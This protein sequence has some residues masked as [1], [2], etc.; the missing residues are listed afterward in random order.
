VRYDTS[1]LAAPAGP[2][3]MRVALATF[4]ANRRMSA[5]P[6]CLLRVDP[7]GIERTETLARV[8]TVKQGWVNGTCA[9]VSVRG[10]R[11]TGRLGR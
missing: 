2:G 1:T 7:L 10:H 11:P 5:G 8:W 6:V 9:A 4:A 3:A